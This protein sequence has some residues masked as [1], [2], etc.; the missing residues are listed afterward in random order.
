MN[1]YIFKG[2]VIKNIH[3]ENQKHQIRCEKIKNKIIYLEAS[4]NFLAQYGR[5]KI[6]FSKIPETIDDENLRKKTALSTLSDTDVNARPSKLGLVIDLAH[7]IA[8]IILKK[9]LYILSLR[10]FAKLCC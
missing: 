9:T 5:N 6:N 1:S 7:Q 4:H 2:I 3:K 8:R 10:K